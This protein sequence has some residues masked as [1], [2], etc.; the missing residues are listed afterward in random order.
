MKK[1]CLILIIALLLTGCG[2]DMPSDTDVITNSPGATSTQTATEAIYTPVLTTTPTFAPT[3]TISP[4]EA[5]SPTPTFSPTEALSPTPTL[6]VTPTLKP[7]QTPTAKP[8]AK[9][10]ATAAVTPTP[11]A[12]AQITEAM[13]LKIEAGFLELVNM[14]RVKVGAAPLTSNTYLR[15]YAYV[16]AEETVTLF[17][18]T[19]PDGTNA[20]D[21]IDSDKYPYYTVG[22]NICY[23]THLGNAYITPETR[24]F[25]GSDAQLETLSAIIFS[26]FKNSPGH[27]QNMINSNFTECGIGISTAVRSDT[28]IPFFYVAHIFGSRY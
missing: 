14:E 4:T 24:Y 15:D 9:P 18:H 23:T 6:T 7:T 3:P 11:A 28:D 26:L 2:T 19:R 10:T 5:L 22:E 16:R 17:S 13:L 27:Y 12:H 21:G 1:L 8:T 20:L 25:T